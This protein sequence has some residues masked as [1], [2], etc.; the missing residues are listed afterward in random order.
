MIGA[1]AGNL[2]QNIE[3]R[4]DPPES[5][6]TRA[7][8]PQGVIVWTLC[9]LRACRASEKLNESGVI[10]EVVNRFQEETPGVIDI[11]NTLDKF[12]KVCDRHAAEWTNED[13]IVLRPEETHAA[14]AEC[15]ECRG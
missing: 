13:G 5:S 7:I 14:E 11:R 4:A 6:H 10:A 1:G 9:L 3:I 12:H 8:R 2:R 15:V